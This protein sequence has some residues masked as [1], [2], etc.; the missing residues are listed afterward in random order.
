MVWVLTPL[1][2]EAAG[3]LGAQLAFLVMHL[4]GG[5][6]VCVAT[7]ASTVGC[8]G[9]INGLPTRREFTARTSI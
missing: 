6:S 2:Q 5:R 7:R 4:D 1:A 9:R 3:E 8:S